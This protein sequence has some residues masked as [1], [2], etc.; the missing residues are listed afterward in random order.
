MRKGRRGA[1]RAG[2]STYLDAFAPVAPAS[3][4]TPLLTAEAMRAAEAAW[5]AA[6]HDSFALMQAA[7]TAVADRAAQLARPGAHILVLCGPGNNGGDGFL[8]AHLL[9]QRGLRVQVSAPLGAGKGDAARAAALWNAPTD[10]AFAD[11]DLIIDA[12]FGIGGGRPL[13]GA[14]ADL[15]EQANTSGAPILA[16]DIASGIDAD[17][18]AVTGPASIA[19][20]TITFHTAK[21][22]HWLQP[23][24]RHRGRLTIAD[25]GLPATPANLWL[26]GPDLWTLPHPT[27]D[28]HKYARG[29]ALIWSGPPLIT[30]A[31]RLSATAALRA[32]AGAVTLVGGRDA[33]AVQAA[34]VTAVMLQEADPAA[35][36]ALLSSPKWRAACIGPGAGPPARDAATAALS[37]GKTLVLD[38]DALTAFADD[39]DHLARLIRR[40]PRPVILT[41]HEGEFARLFPAITGSKLER[42]RAASAT[43]GA[44]V[45]LKGADSVIAAPD[46]CAA[47]Q[48]DAPAWLATAGSGDV[49]A[50]LATGLLAQGMAAFEAAAAATHIHAEAGRL[51]GAGLIS[52]DLAGPV[53]RDVLAAL[54]PVA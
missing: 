38:A 31:S 14:L 51:L 33:L 47:I 39:P 13:S 19:A 32:G 12:L 2:L 16:V 24:R 4:M 10:A 18:G 27:A 7:A 49:L 1:I 23:G 29:G 8:A 45:I 41:P 26:N 25:I 36:A 42:A 21:P 15:A 35:F 11:A 53:L 6:G 50:G 28:T 44:V 30:G 43:S 54:I 9:R 22:G 52:E 48:P 20:E 34:H 17:S 40:H 46:G 3:G 5:F 37:T